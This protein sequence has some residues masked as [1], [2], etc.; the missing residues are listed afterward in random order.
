M[1]AIDLYDEARQKELASVVNCV[2]VI[3]SVCVCILIVMCIYPFSNNY[4]IR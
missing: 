4:N 1:Y 3:Y 2:T